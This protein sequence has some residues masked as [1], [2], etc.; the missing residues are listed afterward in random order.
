MIDN[1]ARFSLEFRCRNASSWTQGSSF[2][3]LKDAKECVDATV[4]NCD[5]IIEGRIFDWEHLAYRYYRTTFP[6]KP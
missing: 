6:F 5:Y 3:R 4:R 1:H 2:A